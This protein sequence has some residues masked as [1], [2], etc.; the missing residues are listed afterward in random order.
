M[1]TITAVQ[2]SDD[3][4]ATMAAS[5][6]R[7]G[8]NLA[9]AL[10]SALAVAALDQLTKEIARL[11]LPVGETRH[12]L[13]QLSYGHVENSA[14]RLDPLRNGGTL[15]VGLGLVIIASLSI[16]VRSEPRLGRF[17]T[18]GC[19]FGA[20]GSASD[21]VDWLH[22]GSVTDLIAIGPLIFN[23]ADLYIVS[24]ATLALV[25]AAMYADDNDATRAGAKD[26]RGPG[27]ADLRR[28]SRT[29]AVMTPR[30]GRLRS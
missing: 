6:R 18:L 24:G 16:I 1:Q 14:I 25:V 29:L 7:I 2:A 27:S 10:L 28:T 22:F 23:L 17:I 26:A 3:G 11:S 5:H 19:A 13:G 15:T 4:T 20:A 12:V 9:I 21:L 8:A 30:P